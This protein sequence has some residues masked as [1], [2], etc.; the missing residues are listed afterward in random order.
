MLAVPEDKRCAQRFGSSRADESFQECDLGSV[1]RYVRK[2][3]PDGHDQTTRVSTRS[4]SRSALWRS[5]KNI[6]PN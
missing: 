2:S 1:R 6:R 5:A 4:I 3:V